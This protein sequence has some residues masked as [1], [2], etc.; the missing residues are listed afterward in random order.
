MVACFVYG[1]KHRS[2]RAN[3]QKC[4]FKRF[5]RETKMLTKWIDVIRRIDKLPNEH[6]RVCM[7]HFETQDSS[8]PSIFPWNI[9]KRFDF[10]FKS[11]ERRTRK[12]NDRSFS[13][14]AE[15][16]A[17][18]L[19]TD[20]GI[21]FAARIENVVCSDIDDG[22][23]CLQDVESDPLETERLDE[24]NPYLKLDVEKL[25]N[26]NKDFWAR[27]R[28]FASVQDEFEKLRNDYKR[29]HEINSYL[30]LDVEKLKNENEDLKAQIRAF[31]TVK[32]ELQDVKKEYE[33]S[34]QQNFVECVEWNKF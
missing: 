14:N 13:Q 1:C 29:L 25:K 18:C 10:N 27:I 28:S 24:I 16:G 9:N 8:I 21:H 26:E 33:D 7:C 34:T 11:P 31:A 20:G 17:E 23:H 30:K 19:R 6:S 22:I 3:A 2:D 4:R 12:K 5:P 32:D 15:T